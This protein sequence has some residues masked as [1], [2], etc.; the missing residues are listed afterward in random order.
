MP[1]VRGQDAQ[2][3][4]VVGVGSPQEDHT[5]QRI[6]SGRLVRPRTHLNGVGVIC[7][8]K[9]LGDSADGGSMISDLAVADNTAAEFMVAVEFGFALDVLASTP[10]NNTAL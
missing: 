1:V 7:V 8:D 10:V 4:R 3:N 5:A 2:A 6:L 9:V